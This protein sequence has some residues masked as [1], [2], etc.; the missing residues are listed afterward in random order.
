[1]AFEL[2][3][4]ILEAVPDRFDLIQGKMGGF[5]GRIRV[6]EGGLAPLI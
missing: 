2:V 1:M 6:W 3:G 4:T 5:L